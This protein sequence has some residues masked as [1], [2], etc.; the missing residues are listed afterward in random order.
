MP[1]PLAQLKVALVST[2]FELL[3]ATEHENIG[4]RL[5][6]GGG[7]A[8]PEVYGTRSS[9]RPDLFAKNGRGKMVLVETV[10]REDMKDLNQL[11][12]KLYLFYTASKCYAWD[13]HL[14]C[15]AATAPHLKEFCKK[16]EIRYSKL[17][18]I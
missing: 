13:F 15:F 18:E 2:M 16:Q 17:W 3:D 12:E 1:E 11:Q 8:S 9:H 7:P 6:L 4:S 10:T 14:V 5:R